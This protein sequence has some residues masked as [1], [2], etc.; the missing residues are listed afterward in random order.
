MSQV[1]CLTHLEPLLTLTHVSH[2]DY[3]DLRTKLNLLIHSQAGKKINQ[4]CLSELCSVQFRLNRRIVVICHCHAILNSA[5]NLFKHVL[6]CLRATL[7]I[8][9]V[10]IFFTIYS[11]LSILCECLRSSTVEPRNMSLNF[12]KT[13]S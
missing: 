4:A 1:N 6:D 3:E 9:D 2:V 11:S 10:I 5:P 8:I 13:R 12:S 7:C